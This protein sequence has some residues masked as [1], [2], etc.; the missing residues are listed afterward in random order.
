MDLNLRSHGDIQTEPPADI[1]RN[2]QEAVVTVQDSSTDNP[3]IHFMISESWTALA[4]VVVYA[5]FR[6]AAFATQ[7]ITDVRGLMT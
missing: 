6:S 5:L 7:Y 3:Y 2:D 1:T 4:S